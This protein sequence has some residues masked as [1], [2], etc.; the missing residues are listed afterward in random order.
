MAGRHGNHQA[1]VSN[2]CEVAVMPMKTGGS[3]KWHCARLVT[4]SRRVDTGRGLNPPTSRLLVRP[5]RPGDHVVKWSGG[6]LVCRGVER[7]SC[8][9]MRAAPLD[10]P[11]IPSPSS[12]HTVQP[13]PTT[14][15]AVTT[16]RTSPLTLATPTRTLTSLN[17][18]PPQTHTS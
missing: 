17:T 11:C 10:C 6:E 2:P 16:F 1:S 18:H 14:P 4:W 7:L 5:G 13:P 12:C 15:S 3:V 9:C 8:V